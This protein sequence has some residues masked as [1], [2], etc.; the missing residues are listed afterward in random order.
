MAN[1]LPEIFMILVLS[2]GFL[3]TV[4]T[5]RSDSGLADQ[6]APIGDFALEK[7][8]ELIRR[9]QLYRQAMVRVLGL[10][11]LVGKSVLQRFGKTVDHRFRHACG[12]AQGDRKSTRLNSRSLMR[13]SYAVFC[14]K[15]KKNTKKNNTDRYIHK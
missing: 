1:R 9:G 6:R 14:L 8:S 7:F 2:P 11:L 3:K 15:K 13:I 4:S 12:A 5:L 10:Q